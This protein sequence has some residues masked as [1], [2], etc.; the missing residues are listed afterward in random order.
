M[1]RIV[2]NLHRISIGTSSHKSTLMTHNTYTFISR[3]ASNPI[4][5]FPELTTF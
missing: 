5:S 2:L 1:E 3:F 4:P